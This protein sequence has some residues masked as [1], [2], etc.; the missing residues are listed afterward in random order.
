MWAEDSSL[1]EHTV[2]KKE[3]KMVLIWVRRFHPTTQVFA[4]LVSKPHPTKAI[5]SIFSWFS[6]EVEKSFFEPI[7]NIQLATFLYV[8]IPCIWVLGPVAHFE[9]S[10]EPSQRFFSLSFINQPASQHWR[11][12]EEPRCPT[13]LRMSSECVYERAR[14]LTERVG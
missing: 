7:E 4:I 9:T 8:G 10:S 5:L 6:C 14:E 3:K 1:R 2:L 11:V 13:E 12:S